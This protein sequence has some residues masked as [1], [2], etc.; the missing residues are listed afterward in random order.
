MQ[1]QEKKCISTDYLT[2]DNPRQGCGTG[3]ENI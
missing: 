3:Y 2:A 1:E